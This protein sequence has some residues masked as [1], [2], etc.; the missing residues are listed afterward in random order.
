MHDVML[1]FE[2]ATLVS[3]AAILAVGWWVFT[4]VRR[5]VWRARAS[6]DADALR[7]RL[8]NEIPSELRF[9]VYERD[10]HTCQ[11]CAT[12]S[13]LIVDFVDEVP[14]HEPVRLQ[15]L[16]TRCARCAAIERHSGMM[17]ESMDA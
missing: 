13:D 16:V 14:D 9:R 4:I 8:L 15:D 5:M 10:Q 6:A 17:R 3:L 2:P 11:S 12:T 1:L 7:S